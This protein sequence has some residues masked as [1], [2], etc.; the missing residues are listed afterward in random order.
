MNLGVKEVWTNVWIRIVDQSVFQA[1]SKW[2]QLN[3][4][5]GVWAIFFLHTGR[6][7]LHSWNPCRLSSWIG[8]GHS[9]PRCQRRQIH[10]E[11]RQVVDSKDR[12]LRVYV[13]K[14]VKA[15]QRFSR[16]CPLLSDSHTRFYIVES[17][18]MKKVSGFTICR[19]HDSRSLM[20]HL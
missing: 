12:F 9:F 19:F 5:P 6:Q 1:K 10:L 7:G 13:Y 3:P 14:F 15:S 2:F 4:A 20:S 18:T 8:T 17:L 16:E 11:S